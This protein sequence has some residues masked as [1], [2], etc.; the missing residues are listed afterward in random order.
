MTGDTHFQRYLP[1]PHPESLTPPEE[2]RRH[3]LCSGNLFIDPLIGPIFMYHCS[4]Q[5]YPMLVAE[6]EARGLK[7]VIISRVEQI[8]PFPYDLVCENLMTAPNTYQFTL[9]RSLLT[10]TS[11]LMRSCSGARRSLSITALGLTSAHASS[12]LPTR[13]LTTK[14]NTPPTLVVL[15]IAPSPPVTKLVSPLV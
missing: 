10:L 3:I 1:D 9:C 5:V 2:I 8:S 6:R 14:A 13:R 11:I 15:H 7:N 4:G 12:R